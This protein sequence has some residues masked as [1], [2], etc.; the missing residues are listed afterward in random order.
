MERLAQVWTRCTRTVVAGAV[1]LAGIAAAPAAGPPCDRI[2][3]EDR[4]PNEV[5]TGAT[6]PYQASKGVTF[7]G[8]CPPWTPAGPSVLNQNQFS[9]QYLVPPSGNQVLGSPHGDPL[10][11]CCMTIRW[12]T[13]QK[14]VKIHVAADPLGTNIPV[15][16]QVTARNCAGAI[17]ATKVVTSSKITTP[18]TPS[19][20]LVW[21]AAEFNRSLCDICEVRVCTVAGQQVFGFFID[22]V[23]WGMD[24]TFPNGVFITNPPE[25]AC[26]C[27]GLLQVTGQVCDDDTCGGMLGE[28][29]IRPIVSGATSTSGM[30]PWTLLNT[31]TQNICTT[32]T[33]YNAS[34]NPVTFPEGEYLLRL[35]GTNACRMKSVDERVIK[36]DHNP[37]VLS[38]N[39]P[40]QG[41]LI[42]TRCDPL[43]ISGSVSDLCQA[44]WSIG[45]ST[46]MISIPLASGLTP[47]NGGSAGVGASF[48]A[49][50]DGLHTIQLSA[51]DSC[52]HFSLTSVSFTID[53]TPPV[54]L[55]TSPAACS[56]MCPGFAY[57]ILGRAFDTN[58]LNWELAYFDVITGTWPTIA[59]G[60][61]NVGTPSTSALLTNWTVPATVRPCCSMLRLTV[62]DR[63]VPRTCG[64]P[65]PGD[66]YC[67]TTVYYHPVRL[68]QCPDYNH[69]GTVTV[70]DLFDFLA[71]YFAGC[72]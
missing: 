60:T 72:P 33:L 36:I 9:Q 24:D 1:V 30:P 53:N 2:D 47:A 68:Q 13:L 4:P 55:I 22:D 59:S 3:F 45:I 10:G 63:T 43:I 18:G 37:P 71:A 65:T 54:A 26:I 48:S 67:N 64:Q 29:L 42:S 35:Q 39:C 46:P 32:Q 11:D 70:Q 16:L 15:T 44:S 14:H 62:R 6:Q 7:T 5:F 52:G 31:T 27:D 28:L 58:I 57:Q 66:P 34:L 56:C 49:S 21:S 38:I 17:L 19:P 12:T 61:S 40:S 8:G 51:Q 20:Q 23:E 41:A 50:Q 25:R 69:S